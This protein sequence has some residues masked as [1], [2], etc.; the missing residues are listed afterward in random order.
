MAPGSFAP[1][2][3]PA[4]GPG[5]FGG[6]VGARVVGVLGALGA[7]GEPGSGV[8]LGRDVGPCAA[9]GC[10]NSSAAPSAVAMSVVGRIL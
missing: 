5:T 1:A 3:A 9:S 2:A 8:T 4:F 6:V 7:V 10:A